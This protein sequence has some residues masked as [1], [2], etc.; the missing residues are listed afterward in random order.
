MVTVAEALPFVKGHGTGNDFVLLPDHDGAR[1]GERVDPALVRALCDRRHGIGADGVIR[2]VRADVPGVPASPGAEWFMDY[3]NADGSVAEMCGN[4]VR[5][6]ARHLLDAGLVRPTASV[7]VG[8]RGGTVLV[9]AHEN[10]EF[11]V[12]MGIAHE[13]MSGSIV[14]V[15]AIGVR[16]PGVAV[17]MPNPHAVMYVGDLVGMGRLRGAPVVHPL[18]LFP[19]GAN[20]EFVV[21]RGPAQLGMRVW[22][23]GVGETQS[24]GTGACAAAWV[25]MTDD[26]AAPG[27][28][29]TVDVPGGRLWVT[30]DERGHLHLRGPA[31]LVAQGTFVAGDLLVQAGDE[32]A[33]ILR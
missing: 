33:A 17:A 15:D 4:G 18:G 28:T 21:R 22:E 10:D 5:V 7:P 32:A 16:G 14:H 13:P 2:V 24:C 25:A 29:Y 1:Y 3:V 12:D 9:Q 6:F 26:E 8:T 20:V 11:T 19:D 30:Q 23:R 27:T 31:V